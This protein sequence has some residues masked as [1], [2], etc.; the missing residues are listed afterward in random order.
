MEININKCG[1]MSIAHGPKVGNVT[2][3]N[4]AVER[5]DKYKYLGVEL[6]DSLDFKAM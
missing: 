6:N 2:L 1:L 5:V 4:I 3:N